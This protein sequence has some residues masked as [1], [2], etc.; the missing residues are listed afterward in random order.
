MRNRMQEIYNQ[1]YDAGKGYRER[2]PGASKD[3]IERDAVLT[4]GLFESE[5]WRAQ[6]RYNAFLDGVCGRSRRQVSEG[7]AQ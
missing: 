3:Q 4:A 1:A 6:L 7:E 2:Y 5:E